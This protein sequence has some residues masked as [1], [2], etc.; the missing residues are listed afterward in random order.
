MPRFRGLPVVLAG[1]L[2][3]TS[4]RAE[5]YTFEQALARA[6]ENT[7][8][9]KAAALQVE[10]ARAA[11][12]AAG[13]LP[14]P[15]L[16]VGIE[17]Y[18]VSG[19]HAGRFGD[20]EMTMA[21]I[22][23]MQELPNRARR[24]AEQGL[25]RSEIGIAEAQVAVT[26]REV[27]A[28]AALAWVDLY[29]AERRLAA[30][31]GI[32][33]ELEP[34]WSAAPAGVSS[35]AARPAEVFGVVRMRAELEDQRSELVAAIGKAGAELARYTG[36]PAASV[37]GAPPPPHVDA[38][39][40]RAGLEALPTLR[41]YASAAE[42]AQSS[43]ALAE[44]ARRP[45]WSVEV[46]YGRRDPMF[47]DMVSAGVSVRLPLFAR[48]RQEPVITARTLEAGKVAAERAEAHRQLV[49]QLEA[50]LAEHVMHHEQWLRARDVVVPAARRQADLETASYG[51]GRAGLMEVLEAF[52]S[53]SE[54]QLDTL[55]RE[56][57]VARDAARIN[58]TYGSER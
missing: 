13:A 54:A 11:S 24:R 55:A 3:A 15:Q 19:P 10:A 44:A 35:G 41:A 49:A 17:N 36:D 2:L 5:P 38:A 40:L 43:L 1:A 25:A 39:A 51:S 6:A 8:S 33:R 47:G 16:K 34:L 14:D 23:V 57:A 46:A 31:D 42:R 45:D 27:R 9:L 18:P 26:A 28:A 37:S 12:R 4:A 21:T 32:L 7:P 58:L 29:Y 53:L 52:T 48:T 22:G 20:D 56:A 30:L 50:D